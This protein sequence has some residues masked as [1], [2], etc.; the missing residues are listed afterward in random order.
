MRH[1]TLT[2]WRL[3]GGCALEAHGATKDSDDKDKDE[4]D[5]PASHGCLLSVRFTSRKGGPGRVTVCPTALGHLGHPAPRPARKS[6]IR[7][8][9]IIPEN[10]AKFPAV[11]SGG[12]TVPN[13]TERPRCVSSL[14]I[15]H[16]DVECRQEDYEIE[17]HGIFLARKQRSDHGLFAATSSPGRGYRVRH[18]AP[19]R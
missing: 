12:K 17:V 16:D 14:E 8:T 10:G 9:I 19:D 2:R 15:V 1:R 5:G 6:I 3:C 4:T 18:G 13:S 7:A 11:L